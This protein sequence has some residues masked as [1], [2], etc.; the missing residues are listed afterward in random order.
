MLINHTKESLPRTL[1]ETETETGV[2]TKERRSISDTPIGSIDLVSSSVEN[3]ILHAYSITVFKLDHLSS[4]NL[5]FRGNVL[6]EWRN[7]RY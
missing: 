1:Q 5:K 3:S 6:E 4:K 7:Y 2:E